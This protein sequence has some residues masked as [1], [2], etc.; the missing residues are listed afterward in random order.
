MLRLRD[1]ALVLGV[2]FLPLIAS[3]VWSLVRRDPAA[4]YS[5]SR[6]AVGLAFELVAGIGGISYLRW[7]GA[8]LHAFRVRL[9]WDALIIGGLFGL[10]LIP[11]SGVI[12]MFALR[13]PGFAQYGVHAFRDTAPMP[14]T[15]V[16]LA[17]NSWFEE[18]FILA[19]PRAARPE[20]RAATF[21]VLTSLLRASYHA[22]QG[23]AGLA[24]IF[25]LG[26]FMAA[27]YW[28]TR[29]LAIPIIAHTVMN[30]VLTAWRHGT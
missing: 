26:M 3:S 29:D 1:A 7:R 9:S 5:T 10:L 18:T 20:W 6:V 14:L 22:Y 2:C 4:I 13:I 17:V 24:S 16:F 28:R 21:I 19:L 23:P 11:L 25:V 27:V 30:F 12:Y 15:L 8:P